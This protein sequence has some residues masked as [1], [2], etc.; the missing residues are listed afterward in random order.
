MFIENTFN[1]FKCKSREDF[2]TCIPVYDEKD[3]IRGWLRPI[4][5]DYRVTMPWC[6]QL[7]A[8]WRNENPSMSSE[9]FTATTT[10]TERWLDEKVIDRSDRI[11][12]LIATVDGHNIGHIGFS[13][14]DWEEKSCEVDAVLRGEKSTHPGLMTHALRALLDW[15]LWDLQIEMIRLRVLPDNFHAIRFYKKN[16]F[17]I[18]RENPQEKFTV[19]RFVKGHAENAVYDE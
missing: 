5:L 8:G 7:L 2:L 6:A 16:H 9:R 1:S 10:G 14:F 17:M 18:E 15:G 11:L 12:F 13:S 19:M 3:K 4:T